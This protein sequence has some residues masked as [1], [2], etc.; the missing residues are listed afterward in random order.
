MSAD[1]IKLQ[2]EAI[3]DKETHL[4]WY[5]TRTRKIAIGAVIF[6]SLILVVYFLKDD[7]SKK[8]P[9]ITQ[10]V[11]H[12]T[13]TVKVSATGNLQ[14]TNKVDVGSELSGVVDEVLVDEND[15][16]KKG[17]VLA[18]LD[19]SRLNDVVTQSRANLTM[20]E[21]QVVQAEATLKQSQ[22][23]FTRLK[24]VAELSG[25]KIPSQ[26]E[27]AKAEAELSRDQASV[28]SANAGVA[29]ARASLQSNL[30]NVN[31]AHI[32]SPINGIVLTRQIE[33]GQ[34]MAASFQAPVLFSL[35]EDLAKMEL[36][37]DIDEA[38][39]GQ[40]NIGQSATFTVDAWPGRQ[41]IATITRVGYGSQEKEGVISYP[42]TLQVD[43]SDLSLRPGMTATAEI[44]TLVHKNVVLIP[45]AALRFTPTIASTSRSKKSSNGLMSMFMPKRGSD[46]RRNNETDKSNTQQVWILKNNE[47]E[48][49]KLKAGASDGKLTELINGGVK[50]GDK[51]ITEQ[52]S[53]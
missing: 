45:N 22:L 28:V 41:Y 32:R 14:P 26:D 2:L 51:V 30:T 17:Q 53:L 16:V 37:V 40:V 44:T 15:R 42:A 25:G 36:L 21:S 8:I 48:L 20:A 34:T 24:K 7:E 10:L 29:Q 52:L 43:N 13:L 50:E 47:P 35:A 31:K 9:Y 49:I 27:L 19:L 38:D 18:R 23:S 4:T 39:V 1:N 46:V 11:E 5:A 3:L 6:F 33:P 12:G